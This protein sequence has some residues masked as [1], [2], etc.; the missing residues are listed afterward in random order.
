MKPFGVVLPYWLDRPSEEALQ[1]GCVADRLGFQEL[2]IGEML[3]FDAFALGGALAATTEQIRLTLGPLAIGVRDPVMLARGVASVAVAGGRTA[4]LA[5]GASTPMVVEQWH[6]RDWSGAAV[7]M[8]ATVEAVRELLAGGRH[9]SFRLRDPQPDVQ[10]T[11]AAFGPRMTEVAATVADRV[12]VN[13]LT[14]AQVARMREAVDA[15]AARSGRPPPPLAAWVPACLDPGP[16]AM[17]QL[18][19]QLVVYLAPP[20]YGEMFTEAGFG[21]VVALARSGASPKDVLSAVPAELVESVCAL[22]DE[23]T[24][25]KSLDAYLDAGANLVGVVP[26]TAE[27]PGGERVLAA[28]APST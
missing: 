11:V 3:T 15:A 14:P 2:W 7:Q 20:G 8:R 23:T 21:D 10:I 12:V 24:I 16:A 9:N 6:R 17:A 18:S 22:G 13:L 28:L 4:H 27:D 5:L 25:R 1:I 19:R 26:V